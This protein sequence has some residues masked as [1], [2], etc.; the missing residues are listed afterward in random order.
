MI[1]SFG[2]LVSVLAVVGVIYYV[3][4][5]ERQRQMALKQKKTSDIQSQREKAASSVRK[6]HHR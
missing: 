4:Y 5:R 1:E 6:R 3:A 2:F